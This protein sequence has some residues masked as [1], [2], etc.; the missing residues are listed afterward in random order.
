MQQLF[1]CRVWYSQEA[2]CSM[3][4]NAA[5]LDASQCDVPNSNMD[6]CY[7]QVIFIPDQ[8]SQVM[9]VVN[10]TADVA[11]VRSDQP[12]KLVASN[13]ISSS[14]VKVLSPVSPNASLLLGICHCTRQSCLSVYLSVCPSMCVSVHLSVCPSVLLLTCLSVCHV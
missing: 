7:F 1:D 11:F 13:I 12:A 2:A 3:A 6:G 10:G 4:K 5:M 9:A 8:Q 14:Q